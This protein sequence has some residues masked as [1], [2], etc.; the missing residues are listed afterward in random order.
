VFRIALP[1]AA[2][3]T[4]CASQADEQ[5]PP[6][7]PE[8]NIVANDVR[9]AEQVSGLTP[10]PSLGGE[11]R[12]AGIDG[13]PFDGPYGLGLS[14]DEDEIWWAPRCAQ[15]A[16]RY[17]IEG[18]TIRVTPVEW[19]PEAA[20]QGPPPPCAIGLPPRIDE[21]T[22]AIDSATTIGRTANNGVELRGGGHS[23]LLFSQ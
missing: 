18:T 15:I 2:M 23:L 12:V 8:T 13:K 14:A 3:L 6:T 9:P 10:I 5:A 11:W 21:V 7:K 4:A 22:R 16:R 17:H 19:A 1:I 20:D